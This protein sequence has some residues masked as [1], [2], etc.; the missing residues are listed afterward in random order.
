MPFEDEIAS[1]G[2]ANTLFDD[3]ISFVLSDDEFGKRLGL[4]AAGGKAIVAPYIVKNLQ[5]DIQS[6]ALSYISGNMPSY[7]L[8]QASLL[9]DELQKV[10]D[11]YIER[12]WISAGVIEV[13]LEQENF[14]ASA[15]INIA[16]PKALWRIFGQ[17]KQTL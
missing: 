12:S 17:V 11:S 2:A 16:E 9:E 8:T 5:V 14:V 1:L 6:R 10:I 15:Y 3:K 7:T 4:F 13:K